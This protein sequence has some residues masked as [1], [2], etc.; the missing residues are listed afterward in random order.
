LQIDWAILF[1]FTL[2]VIYNFWY[3]LPARSPS[4]QLTP[5]HQGCSIRQRLPLA[6]FRSRWPQHTGPQLGVY[7]SRIKCD[8]ADCFARIVNLPQ[9]LNIFVAIIVTTYIDLT[10]V[11]TTWWS[12][13]FNTVPLV[14][15]SQEWDR[16]KKKHTDFG[17]IINESIIDRN[18]PVR[19]NSE[20]TPAPASPA[21]TFCDWYESIPIVN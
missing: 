3:D 5:C 10:S 18:I 21:I 14:S 4:P 2:R 20:K 17:D 19:D 16:A 8:P 6:S 12:P 9:S 7:S 13:W 15:D 1:Y 11:K